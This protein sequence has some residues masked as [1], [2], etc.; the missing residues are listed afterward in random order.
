MKIFR[1]TNTHSNLCILNNS[2]VGIEALLLKK[3]FYLE[4]LIIQI[5]M[6][7]LISRN[8]ESLDAEI[9]NALNSKLDIKVESFLY[10]LHI[11]LKAI[12][13]F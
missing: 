10:H 2:T 11:Y 7:H 1:R 6:V 5:E 13:T 9:L 4:I 3:S 12:I 8:I